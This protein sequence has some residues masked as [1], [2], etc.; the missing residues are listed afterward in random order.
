VIPFPGYAPV[1]PM[2][3]N[4]PNANAPIQEEMICPKLA[5]AYV[6]DQPYANFF[7][8]SEALKKGT[9]FQSLYGVYPVP[10]HDHD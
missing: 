3:R 6:P 9:I 2:M 5:H 1:H 7:S 4:N 10:K 8:L